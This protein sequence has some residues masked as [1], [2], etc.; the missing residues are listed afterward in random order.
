MSGFWLY[1]LSRLVCSVMIC[2]NCDVVHLYFC[3]VLHMCESKKPLVWGHCRT[4]ASRVSSLTPW[5]WQYIPRPEVKYAARSYLCR[6]CPEGRAA[7]CRQVV[8]RQWEG[9][10]GSTRGWLLSA[11]CGP[12]RP[13]SGGSHLGPGRKEQDS[14]DSQRSQP[15]SQAP[16]FSRG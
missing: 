10:L 9:G 12:P 1:F 15:R 16:A 7:A 3:T 2:N 6:E 14:R 13:S 11:G 5:A 8:V 4:E